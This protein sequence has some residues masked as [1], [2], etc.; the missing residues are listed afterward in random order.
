MKQADKLKTL[1]KDLQ[2]I[3]HHADRMKLM[4]FGISEGHRTV[5]RQMQ[6][7]KEGKTKID[8][9]KKL[10]KH[11]YNPSLAVDLFALKDGK[12]DFN[13][14]NIIYLAGIIVALSEMFY[15]RGMT[16]YQ[17]RWGGN[18]DRD[19]EI[20]TDQDFDDLVHFELVV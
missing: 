6:L 13:K 11:N 1:H 3:L 4:Q 15:E 12:A 14:D 2:I 9:I 20:I 18:W 10:S 17:I 5:E 7:F 16:S 19:G 8:G